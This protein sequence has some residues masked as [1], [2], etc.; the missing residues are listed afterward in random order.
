MAIEPKHLEPG[1]TVVLIEQSE[2]AQ[3][4]VDTT[5]VITELY[6]AMGGPAAVIQW[7]IEDADKYRDRA[8]LRHL[9]LVNEPDLGESDASLDIL[10]GGVN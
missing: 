7:D 3:P 9:R 2:R 1:D 8:L 5:G 6:T 4:P 10:L